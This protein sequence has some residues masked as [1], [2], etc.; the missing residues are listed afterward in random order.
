MSRIRSV[1][2]GLWTDEEFVTLTAFARLL[3]MGIWNECD[4][5]GTFEWKPVTLKMRLLPADNV[6]V[7]A[8]LAE[9]EAA[10]C[11]RQY[12][13]GGKKYGAVRNFCKYQRPKKPNSIFPITAEIS[14]FCCFSSETVSDEEGEVRNQFPTG[15]EIAPQM[16]DGGGREGDKGNPPLPPKGKKA[17][18]PFVGNV[19]RLNR[20]DYDKWRGLFHAIPDFDAELMALDGWLAG[21]SEAKQKNWF[22]SAAPWLNKRHQEALE[23]VKPPSKEPTFTGAC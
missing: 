16:E 1:H 15:G 13:V 8:L 17:D 18:Y 21:Q 11:I 5:K 19:V 3:F 23:R 9:I 20:R 7:V 10:D 4:D 22:G 6:D 2:P 14:Q 12:E